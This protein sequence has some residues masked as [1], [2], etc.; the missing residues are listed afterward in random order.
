[1]YTV[2]ENG[3]I[4]PT[5]PT[6]QA[7][8]QSPA[9]QFDPMAPRPQQI[10]HQAVQQG[11]DPLFQG[12]Q[13]QDQQMMNNPLHQMMLERKD[14][15]DNMQEPNALQNIGHLLSSVSAG[16]RNEKLP[17]SPWDIHR[18]RKAGA[19]DSYDQ[20]RLALMSQEAQGK[21]QQF[22]NQLAREGIEIDRLTARNQ[23]LK[24]LSG[25]STPD[26]TNYEYFNKLSPEQQ[27]TYLIAKRQPTSSS[28]DKLT[29]L[30]KEKLL[31]WQIET[32]PQLVQ[33]YAT[34]DDRAFK[35]DQAN[36]LLKEGLAT[37]T[38]ETLMP[39]MWQDGTMQLFT[40]IANDETL[41]QT[42]RLSG[43]L[44]D[45]ELGFLTKVVPNTAYAPEVNQKIIET[46]LNILNRLRSGINAQ[47][48]QVESGGYPW[49]YTPYFRNKEGGS[50]QL[51]LENMIKQFGSKEAPDTGDINTDIQSLIDE[52]EKDG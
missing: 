17:V 12:Q 40:S 47:F 2:D 39:S 26:I 38:I 5:D 49:E 18:Q 28:E 25:G 44:S 14:R 52:A 31:D 13:Q 19:Q 48:D 15:V 32:K 20:S 41:M 29:H 45:T 21:Q 30:Q 50:D 11:I 10:N 35:L 4:I 36:N 16:Y 33:A 23:M 22:D 37:G 1:M 42:A 24:S 27:E 51:E 7:G 8:A 46:Q 9:P 43:A 34:A 3:N 6:I